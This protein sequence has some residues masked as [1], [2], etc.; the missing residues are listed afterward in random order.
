MVRN[1]R[2][3][4]DQ[5]AISAAAS[6]P[7]GASCAA[8]ATGTSVARRSAPCAS[9][10]AAAVTSRST[11]AART[12]YASGAAIAAVLTVGDK[13]KSRILSRRELGDIKKKR[14]AGS[15]RPSGAAL[16]ACATL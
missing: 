2:G 4:F 1:C 8:D 12:T 16:T 10:I 13:G 15:T 3:K 14:A 5:S 11:G 9:Y 6:R 7:A